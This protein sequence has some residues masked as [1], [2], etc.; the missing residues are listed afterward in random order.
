MDPADGAR[1]YWDKAYQTDHKD[2][3]SIANHYTLA[4][5]LYWSLEGNPRF[6]NTGWEY[7]WQGWLKRVY[8]SPRRK[9]LLELG[10]GTGDLMMDL[11]QL[12][13]ADAYTGVDISDAALEAAREKARARGYDDVRFVSGDLNRLQLE[14]GSFDLIVAQMCVHHV[15]NLENLFETVRGAL[16]ADGVLAINEYVGPTLWQFTDAQLFLVNALLARLPERLRTCPRDGKPKPAVGRYTPEEMRALDPSE[17]IRSGEIERVFREYFS[18]DYRVDYGGAVAVLLFDNI[19]SNFRE[20]DP[21]SLRWF[22]RGLGV[23][24]WARRLGLVPPFNVALAGRP[25]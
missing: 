25:R 9:R 17:S 15:E 3:A 18:V 16:G 22:K 7:G 12:E 19:A 1:A 23:D 24:R 4:S 14:P 20:D 6:G 13:L 21:E 8:G 11:R 5:P 2:Q 10:S